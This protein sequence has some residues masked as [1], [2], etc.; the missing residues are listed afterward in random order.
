[1]LRRGRSQ[2]DVLQRYSRCK[3]HN[4]YDTQLTPS[5]LI[6][7]YIIKTF[8]AFLRLMRS[9]FKTTMISHPKIKKI[10][11]L[12]FHTSLRFANNPANGEREY[13]QCPMLMN[14]NWVT[15]YNSRDSGLF[16]DPVRSLWSR[17]PT[18]TATSTRAYSFRLFDRFKTH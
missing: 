5:Q 8:F 11:F 16:Q 13:S 14:A 7:Q 17:P 2:T 9:D 10:P 15:W 6:K 12:S 3:T 1:M 4:R 18:N